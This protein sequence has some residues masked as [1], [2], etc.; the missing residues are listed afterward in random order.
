M[1][2]LFLLLLLVV[3]GG[4]ALSDA[5]AD[6]TII[7]VDGSGAPGCE[8]SSNC[9]S[10]SVAYVDVGEKIT[11][12]N[13][14]SAAHTF[15]SGTTNG[16]PDGNFDTGMLM[17][18]NSFS[19]TP[20]TS[21]GFPYF[22]MLHPWMLGGII[23]Q[24]TTPVITGTVIILDSSKVSITTGSTVSFSGQL[25]NENGTPISGKMIMV[26]ANS[27][28][29]RGHG[30]SAITDSS[31]RYTAELDNFRENDVGNY[32]VFA[33]FEGD[34]Q[35]KKSSSNT[36]QLKVSLP[37]SEFSPVSEEDQK[38]IDDFL[39]QQEAQYPSPAPYG[40]DVIIPRDTGFPGC[41]ESNSCYSPYRISINTGETISWYNAD[42]AA[43]IV[44]SG[45]PSDGPTGEFDS[46]LIMAGN[47]FSHKFYSSGTYNYFC[48]VHPWMTGIVSVTATYTPP[49]YTPPTYT[50]PTYTPPTYTPPTYTPPTSYNLGIT[51]TTAS[52]QGS[53][54]L[55]GYEI[56]GGKLLSVIPDVDASALIVSI[57]T[58]S[59][60]S[61]TLTLPRTVI[62]AKTSNGY[63]DS[64]FVLVTGEEVNFDETT[65]STSRTITI[66]FQVG[67][68]DLEIIG[69]YVIG[70]MKPYD[71]PQ[72]TP[73]TYT[74]PQNIP[75]LPVPSGTNIVIP[76]GTGAP[77]CEE[78]NAC[79]EP[80]TF[81]AGKYSTI[82]WFNSDSAAH[83]VT[84]GSAGHGPDGEFGSGLFKSG[85]SFSHRFTDDGTYNYFCMVHPWMEGKVAI[86]R[87]GATIE[88]PTPTYTPPTTPTYT[89]PTTPTYTPPTTPTYTPPTTPTYTPPIQKSNTSIVIDKIPHTAYLGESITVSGKL[90]SDGNGIPYTVV[91][92]KD[93]DSIDTDDLIEK[94]T[95]DAN[96]RFTITWIVKDMDSTDR[97]L[98]SQLI[99]TITGFSPEPGINVA[100]QLIPIINDFKNVV[101]SNTVEF[102]AHYPG[103]DKYEESFSCD[104]FTKY[105]IL[106]KCND[107][108]ILVILSTEDSSG[109]RILNNAL[110]NLFP[111]IK[112]L[113][114]DDLL[115]S[116][117]GN[118][119]EGKATPTA[120]DALLK[121]INSETRKSSK[122]LEDAFSN[123][124]ASQEIN[125]SCF[126]FWCW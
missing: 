13:T 111:G 119:D 47:S 121:S 23:V 46:G 58:S 78:S 17:T 8:V 89:P 82:T 83:T 63:D 38:A 67:A 87:S 116:L 93:L 114:D 84:S 62:D 18:G 92:I 73:P 109:A 56:T 86:T 113:T 40:T 19:Y 12:S 125:Q 28:T 3:S 120:E 77:G 72:Y 57:T 103:D 35:Y 4:F 1:R 105:G 16:G 80:R 108:Q 31:G 39:K 88:A 36:R 20:F 100:G 70:G 65:T 107:P 95:T 118:D 14:D 75:A 81:S 59:D 32:T 27:D 44:T 91:H 85:E 101:Q 64:F 97:T 2:L 49:T 37:E 61:L 126:L 48:M 117:V 33:E 60:G 122:N 54:D 124:N 99:S 71:S 52:V 74:P 76:S 51:D 10:P 24:D 94:P 45:S 79:Y 112:T 98:V 68:K 7:P 66:P 106:W 110:V 29:G 123:L 55:V 9:Y 104:S 21:G 11:F 96:G 26:L 53:S 5:F 69:T 6:V 25:M 34:S 50:P 42:S 22:C 90:S 43:H 15:T 30:K 41:D 115:L 102:F